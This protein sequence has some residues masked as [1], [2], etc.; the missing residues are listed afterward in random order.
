MGR[1]PTNFLGWL[2]LKR[3]R[4]LNSSKRAPKYGDASMH[5]CREKSSSHVAQQPRKLG[6]RCGCRNACLGIYCRAGGRH[7]T[8]RLTWRVGV[9][10]EPHQDPRTR[11]VSVLEESQNEAKQASGLRVEEEKPACECSEVES[12]HQLPMGKARNYPCSRHLNIFDPNTLERHS[13]EYKGL[14]TVRECF[15]TS[16]RFAHPQPPTYTTT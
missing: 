14:F 1:A 7:S 11:K 4:A 6:S 9:A 10:D 8:P 15:R 2:I 12:E 16:A 3:T 13:K 5:I